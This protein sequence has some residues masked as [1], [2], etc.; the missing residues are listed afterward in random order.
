M[1][2]NHVGGY[3]PKTKYFNLLLPE[4]SRRLRNDLKNEIIHLKINAPI[5]PNKENLLTSK[6]SN[7]QEET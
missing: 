1:V 2:I 5:L 3:V 4:Y 7:N 6:K